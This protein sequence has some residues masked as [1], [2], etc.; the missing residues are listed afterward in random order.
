[1]ADIELINEMK[2]N[3]KILT[4]ILVILNQETISKTFLCETAGK[5]SH[6]D[7]AGIYLIYLIAIA[8]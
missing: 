1:M 4:I 3:E 8:I 2:W 6:L 7:P 5:K